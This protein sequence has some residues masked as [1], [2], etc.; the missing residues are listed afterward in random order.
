M[1]F[2]FTKESSLQLRSVA[3]SNLH[4]KMGEV[5]GSKADRG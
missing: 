1:I 5:A 4:Q 2:A 3:E